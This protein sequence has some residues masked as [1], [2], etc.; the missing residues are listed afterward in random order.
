MSEEVKQTAEGT[1]EDGVRTIVQKTIEEFVRKEQA[2]SEP[3]YQAELIEERRRREQLERRVNDLV[4]ENRK[5]RAMAEEA[6]RNATIRTELQRI[7]VAKV[8][9]AYKAVKDDIVRTDDGRLVA[10][11]EQGEQGL[12]EYLSHFVNENPEFLPARITGGSGVTGTHR[13]PVNPA[14]M[15]LDR[16]KPGMSS[17]DAERVRQEIIKVFKG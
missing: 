15:D 4:E 11:G 7:G 13:T 1:P 12:K 5:S 8:D 17:E 6:E 9:L 16:I 14:G 3:A 10:R 2:K